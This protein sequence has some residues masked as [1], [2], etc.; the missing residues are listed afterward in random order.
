MLSLCLGEMTAGS[1]GLGELPRG[2]GNLVRYG[3]QLDA[4]LASTLLPAYIPDHHW[5]EGRQQVWEEAHILS[6]IQVVRG[7]AQR[8]DFDLDLIG[9]A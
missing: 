7:L 9:A 8:L 6:N 3:W 4:R 2:A 5:I 1:L